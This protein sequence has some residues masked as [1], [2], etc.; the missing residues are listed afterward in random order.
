MV[1]HDF[2]D[3]SEFFDPA[4]LHL[5]TSEPEIVRIV[6]RAAKRQHQVRVLGSG[7]S[8]NALSCS[9]DVIVSLDRYKGVVSLDRQAQEVS[10]RVCKG[11]EVR[12]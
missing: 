3:Q 7:H 5:P 8:R 2:L 9:Q 10:A 4:K 1:W 11:Q 12:P 6:E